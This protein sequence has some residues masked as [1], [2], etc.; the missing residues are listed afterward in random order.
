MAFAGG[1]SQM[2]A[3]HAVLG[4]KMA[5]NRFDGGAPSHL[6]LDLRCRPGG[7]ASTSHAAY[8]PC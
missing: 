5:D 3:A 7:S 8:A 4:L 6:S 1:M 2:I